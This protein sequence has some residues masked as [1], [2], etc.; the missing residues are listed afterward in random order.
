MK[1]TSHLILLLLVIAAI[2][3]ANDDF[4]LT[5]MKNCEE[6]TVEQSGWFQ[7]LIKDGG[8]CKLYAG[9]KIYSYQAE[10]ETLYY[11]TNPASSVGACNEAVYNCSGTLVSKAWSPAQWSELRS[12]VSEMSQIWEK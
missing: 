1:T 7:L 12:R 8:D 5:Q 3:C 6:S 9:A 11:L 2:G 4:D 10:K